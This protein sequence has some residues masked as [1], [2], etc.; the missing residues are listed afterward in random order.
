MIKG[1]YIYNLDYQNA[2]FNT[3]SEAGITDIF[4]AQHPDLTYADAYNIAV[5]TTEGC[6]NAIEE[7][8]LKYH[9]VPSPFFNVDAS[10]ADPADME[11]LNLMKTRIASILTEVSGI[12][13]VSWNDF[14][15]GTDVY[16]YDPSK[17]TAQEQSLANFAS[18]LKTTIKDIDS[19]IQYSAALSWI[20]GNRGTNF[21]LL[22]PIFDFIIPELYRYDVWSSNW[23]A[24]NLDYVLSKASGKG[25]ISALLSYHSDS[26]PRDILSVFELEHDIN[27]VLSRKIDGY[28][29]WEYSLLPA[30]VTFSSEFQRENINRTFP[31]RTYPD[32]I[33][34]SL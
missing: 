6:I 23:I 25:V 24:P 32:R 22:S 29:L 17:K 28:V 4:H 34:T 14:I 3:L 7:D 8:G 10:Q 27:T 12:D 31:N 2:D 11:Y 18:E 1:I 13:G 5:E 21:S 16:D 30:G 15:Y 26:E 9:M 20:E 33:F 19:T